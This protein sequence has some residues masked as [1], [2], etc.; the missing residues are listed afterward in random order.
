MKCNFLC[1]STSH[2]SSPGLPHQSR[3][4]ILL[5][6]TNPSH[7]KVVG[8]QPRHIP[9]SSHREVVADQSRST[10]KSSHIKFR[11]QRSRRPP[12]LLQFKALLHKSGP[13]LQSAHPEFFRHRSYPTPFKARTV[14]DPIYVVKENYL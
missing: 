9:K 7:A 14:I 11:S 4:G 2:C 12:Q 6:Q 5:S 13:V 1:S 3:R 8:H 10:A